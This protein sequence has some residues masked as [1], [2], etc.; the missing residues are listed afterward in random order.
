MKER[1]FI[2]DFSCIFAKPTEILPSQPRDVDAIATSSSSI[3]VT[4]SP[5]VKNGD[6]VTEYIV[7][8]TI[9]R[10]FD[11]PFTGLGYGDENS[12]TDLPSGSPSSPT[13]T[14]SIKF[15]ENGK[16]TSAGGSAEDKVEARM[17]QIK[18]CMQIFFYLQ[19]LNLSI[20]LLSNQPFITH[21]GVTTGEKGKTR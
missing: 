14:P 2:G 7:N 5:P 12:P 20:F 19:R 6:T 13:V 3:N 1:G 9:L 18:V 11:A 10:S 17:M 8:V 4:W 15:D 16:A 21:V